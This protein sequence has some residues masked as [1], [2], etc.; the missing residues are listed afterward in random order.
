MF[1]LIAVNMLYLSGLLVILAFL[2]DLIPFDRFLI[3][4]A[5]WYLRQ[6]KEEYVDAVIN[7]KVAEFYKNLSA[8][9]A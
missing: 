8:E 4:A 3:K 1:G 9:E 2:L 6:Y 7:D 5:S